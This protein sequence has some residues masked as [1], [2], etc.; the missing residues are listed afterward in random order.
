[1]HRQLMDIIPA[2]I[3]IRFSPSFPKAGGPEFMK[4]NSRAT[5]AQ[6]IDEQPFHPYYYLWS[7]VSSEAGGP[8]FLKAKPRAINAQSIHEQPSRAYHY[9]CSP[10][11]PK[12]VAQNF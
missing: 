10:S 7:P 4:A 12:Q 2:R 6:T 3:N 11:F 8:E 9:M 5:N 1:M